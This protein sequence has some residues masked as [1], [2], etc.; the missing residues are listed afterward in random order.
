MVAY[1]AGVALAAVSTA[2]RR[3]LH[4]RGRRQRADPAGARRGQRQ[5]GAVGQPQRRR[6]PAVEQPDRGVDVVYLELAG[7][8]GAGD[9]KLAGGAECMRNGLGRTD[10]EA[11]HARSAGR[12]QPAPVPKLDLERPL[13]QTSFELG[14]QRTGPGEGHQAADAAFIAWRSGLIRT[15]F[16]ASP[17]FSSPRITSAEGSTSKRRRP[18]AAEVGNA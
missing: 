18:W 5:P 9:A 7:H 6:L 4:Q 8:V 13:R 10:P 1:R 2:A 16:H 3:Q 14:A 11:R 12:R 15:T 17:S